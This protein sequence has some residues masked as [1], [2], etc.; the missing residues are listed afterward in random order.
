MESFHTVSI[1]I[2]FPIFPD[3]IECGLK[4]RRILKYSLYWSSQ[5]TIYAKYNTLF[6]LGCTHNSVTF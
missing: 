2:E 1:H 6:F 3:G 4:K 5:D